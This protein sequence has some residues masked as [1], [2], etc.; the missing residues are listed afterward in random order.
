MLNIEQT[1][2]LPSGK[3]SS[4]SSKYFKSLARAIKRYCYL[5]SL[6]PDQSIKFIAR[7]SVVILIFLLVFLRG[8]V[9][10]TKKSLF[11]AFVYFPSISPLFLSERQFVNSWNLLNHQLKDIGTNF[12]SIFI[13][14]ST[15]TTKFP[16]YIWL[17]I[18]SVSA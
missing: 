4:T 16:N 15:L 18:V 6:G 14:P 11:F 9:L 5:Q 3:T 7:I 2:N 8:N 12:V 17:I 1:C 10:L 13:L